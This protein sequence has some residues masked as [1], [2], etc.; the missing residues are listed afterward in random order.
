MTMSPPRLLVLL[1]LAA[2]TVAGWV[3]RYHYDTLRV[4]NDSY[5][6]RVNR[7]TGHTEFYRGKWIAPSRQDTSPSPHAPVDVP[8]D[9]LQFAGKLESYGWFKGR[10]YNGSRMSIDS[11]LIRGVAGWTDDGVRWTR[12]FSLAVSV[13]PGSSQDLLEEMKDPGLHD[14]RWTIERAWGH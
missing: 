5:P 10:L 1:S 8:L 4:G 2:L 6:V 9:S 14:V 7:F 3:F 13:P 11:L 12:V